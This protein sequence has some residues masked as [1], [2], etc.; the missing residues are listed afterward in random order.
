MSHPG[1]QVFSSVIYLYI[2]TLR[3]VYIYS[4]INVRKN[5][6]K[7]SSVKKYLNIVIAYIRYRGMVY[8]QMNKVEERKCINIILRI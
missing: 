7:T 5:V 4:K 6:A 3:N 8:S 1:C 2:Y